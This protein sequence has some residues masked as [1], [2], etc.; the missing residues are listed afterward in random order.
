MR[1][2]PDY[3]H[4]GIGTFHRFPTLA[5]A[6]GVSL[7]T[8]DGRARSSTHKEVLEFEPVRQALHIANNP[9]TYNTMSLIFPRVSP[10]E[11]SISLIDGTEKSPEVLLEYIEYPHQ[12]GLVQWHSLLPEL[13]CQQPHDYSFLLAQLT[14]PLWLSVTGVGL[15]PPEIFNKASSR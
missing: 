9:A 12:F 10:N 1:G 11:T 2:W 13:R 7:S 6:C 4:I 14:E 8:E 3:P 5:R 15:I